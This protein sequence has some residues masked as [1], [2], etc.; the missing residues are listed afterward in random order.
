MQTSNPKNLIAGSN[1]QKG[2]KMAQ[3]TYAKLK[4]GEWGIKSAIPLKDDYVTVTKKSGETKLEH[5]SGKVWSGNG[6]HLYA[7]FQRQPTASAH[8]QRC[9]ECGR[10]GAKIECSDSSGIRGLCCPRCAALS[11]YERSFA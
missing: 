1:R 2:T 8:G 10:P 6:V 4:N 11:Q 3:I 5:I 7:I 9:A